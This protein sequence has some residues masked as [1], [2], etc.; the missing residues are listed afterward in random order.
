MQNAGKSKEP[1]G[2]LWYTD[3]KIVFRDEVFGFKNVYCMWGCGK[4]VQTFHK[5]EKVDPKSDIKSG[6]F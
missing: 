6:L 2:L 5:F 1:N 4:G 3:F